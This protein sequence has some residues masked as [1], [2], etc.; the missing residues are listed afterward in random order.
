MNTRTR[1]IRRP[2]AKPKKFFF[3][4]VFLIVV[5][6]LIRNRGS[7]ADSQVTNHME[8]SLLVRE[9][10]SDYSPKDLDVQGVKS[11]KSFSIDSF[12][13]YLIEANYGYHFDIAEVSFQWTE[14]GKTVS[15]DGK[16]I[17][18]ETTRSVN[19]IEMDARRYL[20]DSGFEIDSENLAGSDAGDGLVGYRKDSYVCLIET[21]NAGSFN[22][23]CGVI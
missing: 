1:Y 14:D 19:E 11:T 2:S 6:I 21:S 5:V 4:V 17:S 3:I 18:T 22:V 16:E 12:F 20:E 7:K 23:V 15:L 9:Q 10:T 13:N 8:D